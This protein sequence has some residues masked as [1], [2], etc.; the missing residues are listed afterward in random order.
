MRFPGIIVGNT[1][2][3]HK[4]VSESDTSGN[5]WD[6]EVEKLLSTPGLISM[7]IEAA[8]KLIDPALP[9]GF[10]SVGKSA[11]VTHEHP[12][13]LGAALLRAHGLA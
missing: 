10:I 13:V 7:M 12:S 4:T 11:C 1:L 6:A 5:H 2:T 3:L 9:D 8:V